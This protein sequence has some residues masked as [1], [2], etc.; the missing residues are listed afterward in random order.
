[1]EPRAEVIGSLLRPQFLKEAV[2]QFDADEISKEALT[3]AQDRAVREAIT[4]QEACGLDVITDGEMRRRSWT[5][6]LTQSLLGYGQVSANASWRRE[7]GPTEDPAS[8][9]AP[10]PAAPRMVTTARLARVPVILLRRS[11]R[12]Y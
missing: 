6:P 4:I 10:G 11:L 8:A 12:F 7:R 3:E 9:P 5:D 2:R 1:S